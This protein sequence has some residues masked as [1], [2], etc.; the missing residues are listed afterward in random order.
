MTRHTE[1]EEKKGKTNMPG[2]VRARMNWNK[3]REMADK[4]IYHLDA[5]K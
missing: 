5:A 2:H 3:C 1:E 4:Y